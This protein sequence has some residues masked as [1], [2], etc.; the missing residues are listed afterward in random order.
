MIAKRVFLGLALASLLAGC[1]T[2]Q[3]AE[4]TNVVSR[5]NAAGDVLAQLLNSRGMAGAPV[6]VG[7]LVQI[8]NLDQ[9]SSFGRMV[10][11]QIAARMAYAGVPVVEL[12]LRNSLYMS[13]DGGEFLLSRELKDLTLAHKANLAVVGTYAV[14][15][16]EVLVTVKAVDVSTNKV[17]AAHSYS[18]PKMAV[19]SMLKR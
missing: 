4:E 11:E 15:N 6:V 16:Q 9:S 14:A 19:S 1:A 17:I 12:K 2:P 5:N 7:T 3:A 13:K 8:D 18:I 10:S